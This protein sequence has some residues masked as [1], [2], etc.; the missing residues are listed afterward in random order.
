MGITGE[1]LLPPGQTTHTGQC[2][3]CGS[4]DTVPFKAREMMYGLREIFDYHECKACGCVQI[5]AY[6]D[7]I[8]RFYPADYYSFA[9]PAEAP[10]PTGLAAQAKVAIRTLL[11][12]SHAVRQWQFNRVSRQAWV[13]RAPFLSLYAG[14]L[15]NPDA[16]ILDVGCGDGALVRAL[17]DLGY[18]NAVG[19]DP[20]VQA[21]IVYQGRTLVHRQSLGE[22]IGPFDC[23]SM[24]HAFEHMPNQLQVLQQ[25]RALLQ[26]GGLLLLR[27][28]VTGGAAWRTYGTDWVQLDPPRHFYVHTPR[29]LQELARQA[30]FAVRSLKYDSTALQFWGSELYRQDIPLTDPRSP[31]KGSEVVITAAAMAAFERA[32]EQLNAECDGDQV[33]A[34]LEPSLA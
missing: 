1:D 3:I 10:A 25:A 24:H 19:A 22:M 4:T 29:S 6:P 33:V 16:R 18:R 26:P 11:L 23:I 9:P 15:P 14:I 30:G 31:A 20:F 28:P 5:S 7:N 2:R 17:R 34:L 27:I 21:E 8:A 12:R 13:A 32:A